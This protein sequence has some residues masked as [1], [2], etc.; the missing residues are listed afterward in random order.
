MIRIR[1]GPSLGVAIRDRRQSQGLTQADLASRAGVSRQWL[2]QLENGKPS[3]EFGKV[4]VVL[5]VLDLHLGIAPVDP[6]RRG[7][8][9]TEVLMAVTAE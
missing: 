9:A 1:S 8:S 3:V 6:A 4:L 2:S 5:D 7:P